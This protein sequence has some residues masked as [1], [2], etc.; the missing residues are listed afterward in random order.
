MILLS[1]SSTRWGRAVDITAW[2]PWTWWCAFLSSMCRWQG[3]GELSV[4]LFQVRLRLEE[5]CL[6]RQA[7]PGCNTHSLWQNVWAWLTGFWALA[8]TFQGQLVPQRNDGLSREVW[9]VSGNMI[10][11]GGISLLMFS[12]V[13]FCWGL[14]VVFGICRNKVLLT[15]MGWD[16]ATFKNWLKFWGK[17]GTSF[18]SKA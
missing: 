8:Q 7:F 18:V 15:T 2:Q 14:G 3:Q 4:C 6:L 12:Q 13:A 16:L 10:N 1:N 5:G 11:P 9:I 17:L